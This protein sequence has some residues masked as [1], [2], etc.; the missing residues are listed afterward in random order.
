MIY[1]YSLISTAQEQHCLGLQN[2]ARPTKLF[3]ALF[4][5]DAA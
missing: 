5:D 3:T 2:T 1:L 4:G